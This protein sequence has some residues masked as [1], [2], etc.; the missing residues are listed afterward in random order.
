MKSLQVFISPNNKIFFR[1]NSQCL[2][3]AGCKFNVQFYYQFH[4]TKSHAQDDNG[5][6]EFKG[7]CSACVR[8]GFFFVKTYTMNESPE[9]LFK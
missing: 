7:K 9:C 4:Y 1:L 3:A 6:H 5:V 8:K 2:L